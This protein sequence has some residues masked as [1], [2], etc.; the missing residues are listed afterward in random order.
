ME[1]KIYN[2]DVERIVNNSPRRE[3]F[4]NF[5]E[6]RVERV[7]SKL[8][9]SCICLCICGIASTMCGIAGWLTWWVALPLSV[10]IS[11]V[12]AFKF[13]RLYESARRRNRKR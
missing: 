8:L 13:G 7:K 6:N 10:G 2:D 5:V 4:E 3:M 1:E 12:A 9:E 11:L